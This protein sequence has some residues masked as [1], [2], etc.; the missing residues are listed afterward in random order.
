MEKYHCV[1]VNIRKESNSEFALAI[2]SKYALVDVSE[3]QQQ[4]NVLFFAL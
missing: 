1:F 3:F 2:I 4:G